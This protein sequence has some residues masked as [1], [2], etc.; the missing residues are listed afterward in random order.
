MIEAV[1]ELDLIW[2]DLVVHGFE[3]I[4]I[5]YQTEITTSGDRAWLL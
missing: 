1:M 4:L 5:K 2:Q 3:N